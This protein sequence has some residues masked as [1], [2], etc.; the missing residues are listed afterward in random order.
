M[1]WTG[2]YVVVLLLVAL[3]ARGTELTCIGTDRPFNLLV[4]GDT[5]AFDY[6]GGTTIGVDP[7][8]PDRLVGSFRFSLQTH[9]GPVAV[10]LERGNCPVRIAT[11]TLD[12]DIRVE[13]GRDG[14]IGDRPLRG[15]CLLEPGGS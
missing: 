13:V 3:P 11:T 10:L 15:C 5:A 14:A 12:L 9:G 7:P 6:L 8:L 2:S 1:C 4:A